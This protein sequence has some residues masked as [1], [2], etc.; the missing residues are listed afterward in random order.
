M[1][2]VACAAAKVAGA[3]REA[4]PAVAAPEAALALPGSSLESDM[5]P[6]VVL[7][8]QQQGRR[9]CACVQPKA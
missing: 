7:C 2:P 5:L 4:P 1:A 6:G 8:Q 3:G 9:S